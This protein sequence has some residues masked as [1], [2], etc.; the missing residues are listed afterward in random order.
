[1]AWTTERGAPAGKKSAEENGTVRTVPLGCRMRHLVS[2][3]A[4]RPGKKKS[5]LR[6]LAQGARER[7]GV[8]RG[9]SVHRCR[10][11]CGESKAVQPSAGG[12]VK[13]LAISVA[14]GHVGR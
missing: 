4:Q 11:L 1:M 6:D 2:A 5:A 12:Q 13:R 7:E 8:G 9:G 3:I 14:P 10:R